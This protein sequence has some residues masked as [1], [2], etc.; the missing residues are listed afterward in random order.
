MNLRIIL[1]EVAPKIKKRGRENIPPNTDPITI[2]FLFLKEITA[3]RRINARIK[4]TE[5]IVI[6]NQPILIIKVFLLPS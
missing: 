3:K 1:L 5:N 2:S 6:S 4:K